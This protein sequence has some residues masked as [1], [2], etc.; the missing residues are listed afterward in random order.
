MVVN[1]ISREWFYRDLP[2]DVEYISVYLDSLRVPQE[3]ESRFWEYF[4]EI[5]GQGKFI[6]VPFF[7]RVI[8]PS[9]YSGTVAVDEID[10]TCISFDDWKLNKISEEPNPEYIKN[11]YR[12]HDSYW[13]TDEDLG[14]CKL[15]RGSYQLL[16]NRTNEIIEFSLVRN[17]KWGWDNGVFLCF[18]E[19]CVNPIKIKEINK[20]ETFITYL[21]DGTR[22]TN[23]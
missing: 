23:S 4:F 2:K 12:K 15:N 20:K 13:I 22:K 10:F 8:I 16:N 9:I 11:Y 7:K 3:Y 19:K 1:V 14:I 5:E 18:P 17:D 21:V 6:L